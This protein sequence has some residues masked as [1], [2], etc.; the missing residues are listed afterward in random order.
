MFERICFERIVVVVRR[1]H[2]NIAEISEWKCTK[3]AK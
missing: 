1:K 2:E 3:Y